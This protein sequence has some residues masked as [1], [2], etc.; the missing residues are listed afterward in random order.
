[1]IW[2][3]YNQ[4]KLTNTRDGIFEKNKKKKTGFLFIKYENIVVTDILY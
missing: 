2:G 3:S 4:R 1:M